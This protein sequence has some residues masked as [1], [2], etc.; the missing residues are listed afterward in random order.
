MTDKN[1]LYFPRIEEKE[2][3]MRQAE[4]SNIF[5][6]FRLRDKESKN[7]WVPKDWL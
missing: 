1:P 6:S 2:T 5:F 3:L 4:I 7:T